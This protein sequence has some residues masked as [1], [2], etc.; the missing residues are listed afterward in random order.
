MFTWA[1][2]L[3]IEDFR[4]IAVRSTGRQPRIALIS[5]VLAITPSQIFPDG[6]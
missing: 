5:N 1:I 3:E 4:P 6:R 2:F